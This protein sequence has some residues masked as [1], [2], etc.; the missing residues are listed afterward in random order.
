[1]KYYYDETRDMQNNVD[2]ASEELDYTMQI[3]NNFL[4]YGNKNFKP[5]YDNNFEYDFNELSYCNEEESI[6]YLSKL[7]NVEESEIATYQLKGCVQRDWNILYYIKNDI[8]KETLEWINTLYFN[9]GYVIYD[10]DNCAYYVDSLDIDNIKEELDDTDAEL[11]IGSIEDSKEDLSNDAKTKQVLIRDIDDKGVLGLL[12]VKDN[13][14]L[15]KIESTIDSLCSDWR[16]E[17]Y[18]NTLMEYLSNNL[19]KTWHAILKINRIE[20]IY[21]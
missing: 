17:D 14:A 21:I 15:S 16:E 10:E 19:P 5:Y 7:W 4:I 6:K 1:M 20:E 9:M 18:P 3:Y 11:I 12:Q 8:S 13:I 2:I